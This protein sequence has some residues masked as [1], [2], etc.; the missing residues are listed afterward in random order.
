MVSEYFVCTA[1]VRNGTALSKASDTHHSCTSEFR[2]RSLSFRQS[3]ICRATRLFL[4][5][6]KSQ[7]D[8]KLNSL[9][10]NGP[11]RLVD[12][13]QLCKPWLNNSNYRHCMQT[14]PFNRKSDASVFFH[15]T[16]CSALP[17]ALI[18]TPS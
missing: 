2:R 15:L 18:G 5:L 14:L 17:I 6:T 13:K 4:I 3:C 12:H 1:R 16:A 7:N 10:A 8:S 9:Q 11:C